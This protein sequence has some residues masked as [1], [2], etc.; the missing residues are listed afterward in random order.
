MGKYA[1][2]YV[3]KK[4]HEQVLKHVFEKTG[5]THGQLKKFVED[6]VKQKLREEKQE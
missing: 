3:D 2:F 4:L 5:K 1:K 6:A